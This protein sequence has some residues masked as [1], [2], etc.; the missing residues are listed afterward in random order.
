MLYENETLIN[1][2]PACLPACMPTDPPA[3]LPACLQNLAANFSL[4]ISILKVHTPEK[5]A[6]LI[7]KFKQCDLS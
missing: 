1:K 5:I 4:L 2:L 6:V 3:H 7:L